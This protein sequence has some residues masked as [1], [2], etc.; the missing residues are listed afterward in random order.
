MDICNILIIEDDVFQCK[1]LNSMLSSV[2]NA[3]IITATNG[4]HGLEA[5]AKQRPDVIFCDLYMPEMDGVEFARILASKEIQPTLVF[6]SSAPIDV[7]NAVVEMSKSYGLEKVTNLIKPLRRE[8]VSELLETL[9]QDR[10][11]SKKR[12]KPNS[13]IQEKEIRHA[14]SHDEFEPY[15]QAHFDAKNGHLVGAEALIRWNHPTLGTLAPNHFLEKLL[16]MGLSYQLTF[17]MLRKSVETAAMWHNQG[18]PLTVSVNVTPSDIVKPDFADRVLQ[19]IDEVRFP[20]TKLILEVTETELATDLARSLENT[21]RLR[22]RGVSISIDDF[23]TGHSSLSQLISSPFSELKIDQFFVSQMMQN[24]KHLAAIRCVIALGKS[25][26]LNV[27]AEGVETRAQACQ[28][29]KMGCDVLQGYYL[30]KPK[31][32]NDFTVLCIKHFTK[33]PNCELSE[34]LTA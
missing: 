2:C 34:P 7:Q 12:C 10:L 15:F 18:W 29:A 14:L 21:S 4:K 6:T 33:M 1:V 31:C 19:I 32:S 20:P 24:N 25:L 13:Q 30:A 16:S 3:K 22:M 8:H 11:A 17:Q 26:D 27:V 23:G 28:L 5:V 9:V